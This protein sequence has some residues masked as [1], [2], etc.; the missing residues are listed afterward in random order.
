MKSRNAGPQFL[1]A[2]ISE[3]SDNRQ[4]SRRPCR[5]TLPL[6]RLCPGESWSKLFFA[7]P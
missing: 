5:E 3:V 6:S 4:G 2:F 1:S 7:I